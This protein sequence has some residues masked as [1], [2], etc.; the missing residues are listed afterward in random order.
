MSLTV[1][2]AGHEQSPLPNVIVLNFGSEN[3]L[4]SQQYPVVTCPRKDF[5]QS[6]QYPVVTYSG[7]NPPSTFPA[8]QVVRSLLLE[9]L[10][11]WQQTPEEN[12]FPGA[13]WPIPVA[14]EEAERFIQNLLPAR[15]CVLPDIYVAHDGEVNF[16]WKDNGL[17]IDLG[18]YGD[19]TYSYYAR[20]SKG[21]EYGDDDLKIDQE[22]DED[23]VSLLTT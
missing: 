20:D 5:T 11:K 2:R 3:D 17:H 1:R 8:S 21:A 14:F 18:F 7:E 23:L 15:M 6:Q 13:D 16:L 22:L 9:R 12:R 10:H 4:Q 19:G